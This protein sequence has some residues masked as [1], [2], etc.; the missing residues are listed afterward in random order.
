MDSTVLDK[1]AAEQPQSSL[2]FRADSPKSLRTRARILDA[3]MRLFA[4]CGY[5][6]A[7]NARIADAAR[8]TR[9]AMLYHFPSR[10]D[11]VEAAVEHIQRA[12]T[13]LFQQ[14]A[15]SKPADADAADFAIDSYWRLLRETPFIAF[16]E[17]E[18]AARSD[19]WLAQAVR[20]AQE[21]F[22]RLQM[23]D[24]MAPLMQAGAGAR[25]QA[26]RD[27][28]RFLLEGLSRAALADDAD[29]RT[30]RLLEVVK[31]ATH[32]LNRKGGVQELW[33]ET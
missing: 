24:A 20:P 4:E 2:R 5:A 26:S 31:R 33:P 25:F 32:I 15:A 9:G 16:A 14:A 11:L 12:R 10:E 22:D 30:E 8:L 27:L 23:G 19:E 17:L 6:G 18:A 21:A 13:A 7:T 29:G 28:A 1:P 3:A